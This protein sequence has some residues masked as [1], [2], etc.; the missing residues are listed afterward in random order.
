MN[1]RVWMRYNSRLK[2]LCNCIDSCKRLAIFGGMCYDTI[3]NLYNYALT[4][5][6][7]NQI[8]FRKENGYGKNR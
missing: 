5:G 2:S 7:Y 4:K 3:D 1:I 6:R 8:T